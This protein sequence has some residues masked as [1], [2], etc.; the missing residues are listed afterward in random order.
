[1]DLADKMRHLRNRAG[2]ARGLNRPLTQAE[3]A[4]AIRAETG[5]TISQAYLS[6]LETGKR[7][8][9][10]EK[11]R[12]Q[13]ARF[14]Q[15]HPGYLVSDAEPTAVPPQAHML[16]FA[17]HQPAHHTL[18]RL[19]VHPHRHRLWGLLDD[20]IDLPPADLDEIHGFVSARKRI[21]H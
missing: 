13:L 1:M 18:A 17:L 10:T 19:A 12:T 2:A 20:L 3:L 11:T 14:F 21:P 15:V 4:R 5:G 9:L 7:T 8:H 6:Q 16:P